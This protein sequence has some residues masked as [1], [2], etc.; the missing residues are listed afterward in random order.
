MNV[1]GFKKALAELGCDP[2]GVDPVVRLTL[3]FGRRYRSVTTD[4]LLV[5]ALEAYPRAR[6]T[7]RVSQK[8]SFATHF[9]T[10]A[11]NALITYVNRATSRKEK[12]RT[13]GEVVDSKTSDIDYEDTLETLSRVLSPLAWRLLNITLAA[14]AKRVPNKSVARTLGIRA[15][16][17]SLLRTEVA[18][19][20][21]LILG[22]ISDEKK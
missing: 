18:S 3:A 16:Q 7:Y 5:R 21:C 20:G 12:R 2:K 13:L 10:V 9:V 6:E 19:T 22:A 4:E 1:I 8:A 15:D 14:H 11:R 17:V